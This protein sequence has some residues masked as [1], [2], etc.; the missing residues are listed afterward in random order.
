MTSPGRGNGKQEPSL[1]FAG[2]TMAFRLEAAFGDAPGFEPESLVGS[3]IEITSPWYMRGV[4]QAVVPY[5][6]PVMGPGH[7][8]TRGRKGLDE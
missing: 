5:V 1:R 8:V 6:D 4:V 2:A 3:T 7:W